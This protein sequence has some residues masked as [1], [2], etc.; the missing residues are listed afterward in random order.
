MVCRD[1]N[2]GWQVDPDKS[3]EL[4]QSLFILLNEL[5]KF[6]ILYL[7][8]ILITYIGIPYTMPS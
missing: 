5:N 1:S 7:C 2:P 6:A 8:N 4:L 3:S